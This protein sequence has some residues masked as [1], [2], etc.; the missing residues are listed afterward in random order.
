MESSR[1]PLNTRTIRRL[2]LRW[3]AF[4]ALR[5]L[6]ARW[7]S[8][9]T[10]ILGILLVAMI[11]ASIPLYTAA[12]AQVGMVQHMEQTPDV[13]IY[14]QTSRSASETGDL[15]AAWTALHEDLARQVTR[16]FDADLPGWTERLTRDRRN[17]PDDRRARRRG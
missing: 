16:Q 11:G 8:L 4:F 17:H 3:S 15:D 1:K 10:A 14:A 6:R 12:I 13:H 2:S 5:R 7:R 9:T